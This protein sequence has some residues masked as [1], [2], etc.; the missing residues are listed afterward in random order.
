MT[1]NN[2]N[3]EDMAVRRPPRLILETANVHGGSVNTL[4][5]L[6]DRFSAL[7]YPGTGIK[8][9][10]F[11]PEY[12]ALTDFSWFDRIKKWFIRAEDWEKMIAYAIEKKYS[13]WLDLFCRFGV[14]ILEKNLHSVEG[15][16]LQAS[17]LDNREVFDG[18]SALSTGHLKLIL[19]IAGLDLR[20]IRRVVDR[21]RKLDFQ[22]IILQ[23]GFQNFPTGSRESSLGKIDVLRQAFPS[24]SLG[25]ADH[26]EGGTAESVEFPVLAYIAGCDY[27]E[28]HICLDRQDTEIDRESA[29]E[30]AEVKELVTKIER[31]TGYY[32]EPFIGENEKKYLHKT[33]QKVVLS[34]PLNEGQLVSKSDVV[35]R[36]T[37]RDGMNM[38]RL[39]KIQAGYSVLNHP[40]NRDDVLT[41]SEFKRARIGAIVAC[42]MKSSRL[43]Q[44]ALRLIG[45]MPAI[46]RCLWNCLNISMVDEVVLATSDLDEDAVLA[47]HLLEGRVKFWKG[48][49]DDVISRYLGACEKYQLDVIVRIT[50][51][52]PVVSSDITEI[53]IGS[54][55]TAGAD[56][57]KPGRFALGTISE[58]YNVEVLKRISRLKGRAEYSEH[59]TLY[60]TS[61]PELFKINT[62]DLPEAL[63][64]DYR[65]TLDYPEDLE[66]FEKLFEKLKGETGATSLQKIF[67]VLEQYP[68]ISKINSHLSQIYHSDQSLIEK[69]KRETVI[70]RT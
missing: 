10:P 39:E 26:L 41:E 16:K 20:T 44:K 38:D 50:G 36:R 55:F 12:V 30:Q 5:A 9:H 24:M 61:N 46:E 42:R 2:G 65:L 52:S 48:D 8:F 33:L 7:H 62:V 18:I 25:Y 51:D 29:L 11:K 66:M 3:R 22:E 21:Y 49:P 54:H 60:V 69:L 32:T 17:V 68:E 28:K 59:M 34:E 64:G 31:I 57:T 4:L 67:K 56:F 43:K 27:L 58:I 63:I 6:M 37:D 14:G 15:I 45:G 53:L 13:P 35:F 19:N 70:K 23:A 47:D 40:K 1:E